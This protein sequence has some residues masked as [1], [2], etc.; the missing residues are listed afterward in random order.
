MLCCLNGGKSCNSSVTQ[1]QSHFRNF[2]LKCL[3]I[4]NY[5][6]SSFPTFSVSA[7]DFESL[8]HYI[9]YQWAVCIH[10]IDVPI[11]KLKE[12]CTPFKH[13]LFLP[14][15]CRLFIE[16]HGMWD[17]IRVDHGKEFYLCLY[18]QDL[19]KNYHNN[20]NRKPY[21]QTQSKQ[22]SFVGKAIF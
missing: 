2:Y 3:V 16:Q 9:I 6:N 21:L 10:Y 5:F 8:E 17:Q 7:Y 22:V 12:N 11:E 4:M 1:G 18:V 20:C 14:H 13:K 15:E 19:L